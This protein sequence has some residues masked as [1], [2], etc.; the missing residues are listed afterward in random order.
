LEFDPCDLEVV[1]YRC[2][3]GPVQSTPRLAPVLDMLRP[4]AGMA[5]GDLVAAVSRYICGH[6][7]YAPDVTLANSPIDDLLAHG[8]GVCQ[9]FTD[10]SP[11]KG[12][13]RVGGR[14]KIS[15]RVET[16]ELERLPALS[17]QEQLPPLHVPLTALA[18]RRRWLGEMEDESQ[19]Q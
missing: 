9:D 11:N 1:D 15:V 10:V 5:L 19:Q 3:R 16:R 13:Y 8:K 2:F 12:V 6:F 18:A 14:E 7:E 17:W 4:H